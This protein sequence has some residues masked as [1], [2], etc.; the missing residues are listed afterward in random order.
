[1]TNPKKVGFVTCSNGHGHAQRTGRI[2]QAL[3][4][5]GCAPVIYVTSQAAESLRP[6]VG[7]EIRHFDTGT[8]ASVFR[9]DEDGPRRWLDRLPD[10]EEFDVVISDNLVELKIRRSDVILCGS[11][12][13]HEALTGVNKRYQQWAREF[14]AADPP[15][16]IASS[17][18]APP[19][20]HQQTQLHP[21]GLFTERML[22]SSG[23]SSDGLL[24]SCGGTDAAQELGRQAV[25]SLPSFRGRPSRVFIER[26]LV[27]RQPPDW[28][29]PAA[30]DA[31]MYGEVG[32]IVCRPGA[33]TIASGLAAGA[34]LFCFYESENC[35]MA[36]NAHRVH[37][38]D[39][40][41]DWRGDVV[42]ALGA[43]LEY[44]HNTDAQRKQ[45][46]RIDALEFDGDLKAAA[47]ILAASTAADRGSLGP[48][49]TITEPPS[50]LR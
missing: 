28:M 4:D 46:Q 14:L 50:V 15:H 27:S 40:G 23:S 10:L 39:I 12:L 20:L 34:R 24:V 18:L 1:M 47:Y 35:E 6:L 26:R 21:V 16:M 29:F 32:A 25:Q 31:A 11:F 48:K 22:H 8:R 45:R 2:A 13:W 42:G 33:G 49:S 37:E 41:E 3:V 7:V 19:Y 43:A 5:R 38:S 17:L 44:L 9:G 30:F 36:W